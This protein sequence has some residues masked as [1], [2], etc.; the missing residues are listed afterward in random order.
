MRRQVGA[1]ISVTINVRQIND[2]IEQTEH[3]HLEKKKPPARVRR[4]RRPGAGGARRR[5]CGF[6][7]S[8]EAGQ[9]LQLK[10]MAAQLSIY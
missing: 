5:H 9:A 1:E 10:R 6:L 4:R 2:R 3:M 7:A 8:A